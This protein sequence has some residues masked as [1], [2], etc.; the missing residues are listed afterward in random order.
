MHDLAINPKAKRSVL[1]R[2]RA[3]R[4]ARGWTLV[5]LELRSGV[6]PSHT[7][8]AERGGYISPNALS[9]LARALDFHDDPR[10]LL[11]IVLLGEV[12]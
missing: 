10:R 12:A 9:K 1:R 8:R 3:L 4:D 6:P 5:E 2:L 11:D 7:C